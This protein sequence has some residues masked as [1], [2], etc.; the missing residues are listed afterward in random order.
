MKSTRRK[1]LK[2]GLAGTAA[3]ILAPSL[4][5]LNDAHAYPVKL[6]YKPDPASWKDTEVNVAWL[7]HST[8]LI[9]FYGKIIITDPALFER[10]GIYILGSSIGP[11]RMTPPALTVDELPKPD[12]VLLSHGHMDHTDYPTLKAITKRF[13]NQIDVVMAYLTKDIV[14]DLPWHSMSV[15]DWGDKTNLLGIDIKAYQVD[16]FGWRF[17]W[18][19]DRSRGYMKDGRSYNAYLISYNGKKILFGG[20]TRNSRRFDVL[21]S[22]NVDI[23]LMPIGAYNPWKN[24]HCDPEEALQMADAFGAKYFIPMH[25][26]TF[27]QGREPFNEPIDWMKKSAPNY[28][29]EVGLEEIGQTFTLA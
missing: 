26:K 7:G 10:V 14:E 17:P 22:E 12:I 16:H 24:S 4:F 19:R 8:M 28:K 20:D 11:S 3:A 18:E 21:K 9:N 1:F 25:C 2:R 13:P 23:A 15:L 5:N 29:L 27:Q 6:N